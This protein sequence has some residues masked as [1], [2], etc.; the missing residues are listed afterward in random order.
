MK[1]SDKKTKKSGKVISIKSKQPVD[2]GEAN[3]R[4]MDALVQNAM[5]TL[6]EKVQNVEQEKLLDVRDM[7]ATHAMQSFLPLHAMMNVQA[8]AQ[9]SSNFDPNKVDAEAQPSNSEMKLQMSA[10]SINYDLIA[11]EAY[12][13]ADAMLRAR[14][15]KVDTKP[16]ES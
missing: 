4:E 5:R 3:A 11:G 13:M 2:A 15:V 7:M 1:K 9:Y 12:L 10:D 16:A 14:N 6:M 8:K